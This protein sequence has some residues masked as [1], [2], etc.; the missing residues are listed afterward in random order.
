MK[1]QEPNSVIQGH[2]EPKKPLNQKELA[3]HEDDDRQTHEQRLPIEVNSSACHRS[4]FPN[5]RES[6]ER[7]RITFTRSRLIFQHSNERLVL[8]PLQILAL[9]H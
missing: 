9:R 8:C 2:L 4:G 6:R 1:E 3:T 5:S 7:I